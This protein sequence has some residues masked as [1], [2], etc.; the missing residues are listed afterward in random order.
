M[1][2]VAIEMVE[3][4]QGGRRRNFSFC[5]YLAAVSVGAELMAAAPLS[6]GVSP[7]TA[8]IETAPTMAL[9]LARALSQHLRLAGSGSLPTSGTCDGSR[10]HRPSHIAKIRT[11]RLSPSRIQKPIALRRSSKFAPSSVGL[12]I[13][14]PFSDRRAVRRARLLPVIDIRRRLPVGVVDDE[15]EAERSSTDQA[16]GGVP[17]APSRTSGATS[18][19]SSQP[20]S[21]AN[22]QTT[23]PTQDTLPSINEP[24]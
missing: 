15:T 21:L 9:G 11:G 17:N 22:A 6:N 16:A 10:R 19:I 8:P 14:D 20:S 7:A 13:E 12:S 2:S 4:G 3:G 5:I 23:S 1:P 24:L 18:A